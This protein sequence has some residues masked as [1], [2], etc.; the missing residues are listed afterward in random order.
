MNVDILC[1]D[2]NLQMQTCQLTAPIAVSS[3]R[4]YVISTYIVFTV[5]SS[6]WLTV[7][8][9]LGLLSSH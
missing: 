7:W 1:L 3:V 8:T 2:N 5:K 6:L 4:A 9:F